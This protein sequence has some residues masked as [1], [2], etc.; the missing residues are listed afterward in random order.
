MI[1]HQNYMKLRKQYQNN[2]NYFTIN[3]VNSKKRFLFLK[4][5]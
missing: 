1:Y 5:G 4:I 2:L 3:Q